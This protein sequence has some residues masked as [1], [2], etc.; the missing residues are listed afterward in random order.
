MQPGRSTIGILAF[1]LTLG[2]TGLFHMNFRISAI[3][4]TAIGGV[5]FALPRYV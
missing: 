1:A 2:L 5:S 3:N 4:P